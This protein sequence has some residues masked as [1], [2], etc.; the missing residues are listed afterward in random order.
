[1]DFHLLYSDIRAFHLSHF[2]HPILTIFNQPC[3]IDLSKISRAKKL[4]GNEK[5]GAFEMKR[6]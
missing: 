3:E 1:M 5:W 6:E 2:D 4:C